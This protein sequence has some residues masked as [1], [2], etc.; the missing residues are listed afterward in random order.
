MAEELSDI[1]RKFAL[2]EE[3]LGGAALD[4]GDVNTAIRECQASLEGKI[5]GE[6]V[7]NFVGVKN[8]VNTAWGYPKE[9]RIMELGSNLFQFFLPSEKER[10]RILGGGPW[11]FDNQVLVMGSLSFMLCR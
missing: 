3:E 8:F 6:K 2:S 11:M 9:L 4:L 10:E 5:V 1:L 7:A